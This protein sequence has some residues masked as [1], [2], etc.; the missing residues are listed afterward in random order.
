MYSLPDFFSHFVLSIMDDDPR[1]VKEY[2]DSTDTDLQK[3]AMVE[4]IDS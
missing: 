1:N 3:K 4:E 2:I